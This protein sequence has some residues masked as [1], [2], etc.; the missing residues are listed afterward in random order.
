MIVLG[1]GIGLAFAGVIIWAPI[2]TLAGIG[3]LLGQW[4]EDRVGIPAKV[5][6]LYIQYKGISDPI[7][8]GWDSEQIEGTSTSGHGKRNWRDYAHLKENDEVFLLYVTDQLWHLYPKR[9]FTAPEQLEEFRKYAGTAG[10]TSQVA[11][12]K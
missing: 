6:K 3:G 9:W 8:F 11:P 1:L 12:S 5:Q 10:E 7:T 4:W 2:A